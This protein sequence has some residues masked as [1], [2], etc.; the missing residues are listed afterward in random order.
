MELTPSGARFYRPAG[1][2]A[3]AAPPMCG[4]ADPLPGSAGPWSLA[5]IVTSTRID[6]DAMID[7]LPT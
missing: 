4:T 7:H 3:R 1:R 5:P 6:W 2:P